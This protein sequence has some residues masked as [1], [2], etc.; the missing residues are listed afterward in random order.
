MLIW[1]ALQ[2]SGEASKIFTKAGASLILILFL[3]Q[4]ITGKH[5]L[6]GLTLISMVKY[7]LCVEKRPLKQYLNISR[8]MQVPKQRYLVLF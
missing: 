8:A 1:K 3:L 2:C 7:H 5:S 6:Y 4:A